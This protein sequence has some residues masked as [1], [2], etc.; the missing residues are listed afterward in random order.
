MNISE[1]RV[2]TRFLANMSHEIRTPMNSIMGFLELVLEDQKLPTQHRS[3]L[4]TALQSS[5]H[6]LSL[7][8]NILDLSRLE[9][10][11]VIVNSRQFDLQVTLGT[12][13]SKWLL[14]A[15]KKKL[16]FVLDCDPELNGFYFGDAYILDKILSLLLDNAIKFTEHGTVS[17]I[18]RP[19]LVLGTVSFMVKDTGVGIHPTFIHEIF[20]PFMQGDNT[21]SRSYEGVGLGTTIAQKF[22]QLLDGDIDVETQYGVGSIFTLTFSLEVC[23]DTYPSSR[24]E[25][26]SVVHGGARKFKILLVDDVETNLELAKVHLRRRGQ[27]VDTAGNGLEA[28]DQTEEHRYDVILMDIHMPIMD[29][30]EAM[31]QIRAIEGDTQHTIIIALTADQMSEVRLPLIEKGFDDVVGKPVNFEELMN[32]LQDS[33]PA[34]LGELI[35]AVDQSKPVDVPIKRVVDAGS[36][37]SILAETNEKLQMYNPAKVYPLLEDLQQILGDNRLL[38]SISGLVDSYEFDRASNELVRL[39]HSLGLELEISNV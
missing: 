20:Q 28:I 27:D 7:I 36:I 16:N 15:Q 13:Q 12:L 1:D 37:H 9:S 24:V 18:V 34:D 5:H 14:V 19:G 10:H 23:P 30:L 33:L 3:N 21:N 32:L 4:D 26:S 31:K 25:P 38:T 29:G 11:D 22:A 39:A 2:E 35:V 17:L 8:D 6:L